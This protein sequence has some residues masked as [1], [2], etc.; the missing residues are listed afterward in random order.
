MSASSQTGQREGRRRTASIEVGAGGRQGA[1][2]PR[3]LLTRAE[4]ARAL[5]MSL[6]HFQRHCQPELRCVRS[7]QLRLYR[8]RD[9][10]RWLESASSGALNQEPLEPRNS[11]TLNEAKD[12]FIREARQGVAL[13]KWRR[14]Y[15]PRS[16]EDL[17]SLNQLPPEMRWRDLDAVSPGDVQELIDGLI[18]RHLSASRIGSVVSALRALY[19]F[20]RERELTSHDPAR[21][22]RL[23]LDQRTIEHRVVTPAEFARLL[24]A[25]WRQTPEE[26]DAG[27][28]RAPRDA[29][30]DALPYA[31]AAYGTARSQEIEVLDWRHVDLCLGAA[32][33]A[34]DEQGRK[35][36]GSW[37][38]V[39]LVA[40]LQDLLGKE[41]LAQGRPRK[42]MVCPPLRIRKSGRR[43]MRGVQ[44]R[45]RPHWQAHGLE[46][47]GLRDARHTAATWLDHAGVSPKV[48]SQIMG[49]KTPEYQPGAARI[50]LQRYTHVLPG[51]LEHARE[52]LDRFIAERSSDFRCS[53]VPSGVPSV[54]NV[55]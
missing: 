12:R 8:P 45:V 24:E 3:L 31:L 48:C 36:G 35:P 10:E 22:V 29:L 34:G 47:I 49:H 30:Q 26:T 50:T 19:R 18:R 44:R 46:P 23:P 28:K 27:V 14:P 39:P 1:V 51:E 25:L 6:S 11:V 41:W 40:P 55:V 16:V 21:E 37:R 42:G 43:S 13:N 38:V 7:G 9:L 33:L 17:E 54:R 52:R 4:S 20:A 2:A 53:P 15:R 32:E 5:S